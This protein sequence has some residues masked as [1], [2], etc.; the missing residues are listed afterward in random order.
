ALLHRKPLGQVLELDEVVDSSVAAH[1]AALLPRVA[2][3]SFFCS[4]E[5]WQASR[6][7]S[8]AGATSGGR[9]VGH[10]SKRCGQRGW[11]GHPDGGASSEGG[12]PSIGTSVSSRSS[13]EGI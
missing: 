5:R 12:E 2:P 3:S 8:G 10:G 7:A 4:Q 9:S 1:A 13:T 11:N 6:C